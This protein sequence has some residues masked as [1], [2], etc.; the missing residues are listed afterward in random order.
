[1]F[2]PGT[3][4]FMLAP[5]YYGRFG[6]VTDTSMLRKTQ[7][8]KGEKLYGFCWRNYLKTFPFTVSLCVPP[9]PDFN[10]AIERN[11]DQKRF[12]NGYNAAALIGISTNVLAR[13]TGTILVFQG[14]SVPQVPDGTPKFNV[15]LQMRFVKNVSFGLNFRYC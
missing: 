11:K 6:V 7:R 9:E 3:S 4:V 15:G 8:I 13:V 14:M 1:M 10:R 5:Q 2:S 12:H